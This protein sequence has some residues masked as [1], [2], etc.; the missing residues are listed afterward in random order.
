[1]QRE[2][3]AGHRYLGGALEEPEDDLAQS[4]AGL[5][6]SDPDVLDM[7]DNECNGELWAT[8]R[9]YIAANPDALDELGLDVNGR[10]KNY[11]KKVKDWVMNKSG[12]RNAPPPKQDSDSDSDS[13]SESTAAAWR[14][15]AEQAGVSTKMAI[16]QD[17]NLLDHLDHATGGAV[18]ESI[19]AYT[20]AHPEF[21]Q[22]IG[23]DLGKKARANAPQE[24]K[25]GGI[26]KAIKKVVKGAHKAVQNHILD[27]DGSK[28]AKA[29]EDEAKR[30]RNLRKAK[31]IKEGNKK[32]WETHNAKHGRKTDAPFPGCPDDGCGCWT[33]GP[34]DFDREDG[35]VQSFNV[36][37][38]AS[39]GVLDSS[40]L[41]RYRGR[42]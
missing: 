2:W 14:P 21:L 11:M 23:V 9:E 3:Q 36:P 34:M 17:P 10:L 19:K 24:K 27:K 26:L 41:R 12:K 31:A 18:W 8:F 38:A 7:V 25:K 15:V 28:R 6:A 40:L 30:E 35:E 39:A 22:T 16:A 4:F 42:D 32:A 5:V 13:D 1:M 20:A 33:A 37:F 29:A